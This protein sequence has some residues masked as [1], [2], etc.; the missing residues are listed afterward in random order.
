MTIWEALKGSTMTAW[1]P[2]ELS[3]FNCVQA[4]L[5]NCQSDVSLLPTA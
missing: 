4:P 3:G 1:I 5:L 2:C